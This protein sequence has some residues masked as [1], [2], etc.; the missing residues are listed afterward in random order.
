MFGYVVEGDPPVLM[1]QELAV[2]AHDWVAADEDLQIVWWA[3]TNVNWGRNNLAWAVT[4]NDWAASAGADWSAG[5]VFEAAQNATA[6]AI[7]GQTGSGL[8][9]NTIELLVASGPHVVLPYGYDARGLA[10]G[11]EPGTSPFLLVCTV[12]DKDGGSAIVSFPTPA[13]PSGTADL[14]S[15]AGGDGGGGGGG[16]SDAVYAARFTSI[17]GNDVTFE[18]S[19]VSGTPQASDAVTLESATSLAG[20]WTAL[21]KITVGSK[22]FPATINVNPAG[23]GDVRFYRVVQ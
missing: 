11:T 5:P 6:S 21:K 10:A 15:Y 1:V 12:L 23:S 3:T 22:T 2:A 19:L 17:V 9:T 18:L 16:E 13:D 4:N 7:T 14:W 20:P 8:V